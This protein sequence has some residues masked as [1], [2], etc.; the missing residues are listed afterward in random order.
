MLLKALQRFVASEKWMRRLSPVMGPLN[1]FLPE[2]RADPYATWN[3]LREE[4]PI[5]YSR[6]FGAWFV[7]RYEDCLE[8]LSS[9]KASAD[10]RDLALMKWVLWTNRNEPEFSGFLQRSLLMLEGADHRRL[11]GLVSKAFTPR[12]VAALR[13]RLEAL[14]DETLERLAS[15]GEVELVHEF[16]YP[17]PVTAIA[18]LLGVP[19]ED[20]ERFHAWTSDL[21]QI[22]DPFQG[23]GGAEPMRRATRELYAYFRSL[24]E[25]RRREPRDD[26]MTAMLH[27][28]EDGQKLD[29]ND[30]LALCVLLLAAGHE[31]TANLIGNSVVTLLRHPGERKRLHDDPTLLPTAVNELLR[32]ESPIQLTDRAIVEDFELGGRVFKKGQLVGIGIAAANRDP[33]QFEDPD[34]LDLGRDPNA[35]VA[36]GH[37]SHFCLGSQLAKLETEVAL[38]ALLRRYPDFRGSSDPPSWRRSMLLRGPATLP[39]KL[40]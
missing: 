1:P 8:L 38:G 21:V 17:F 15:R 32:F 26:L 14:A 22:L 40:S 36:L 35:H 20:H 6:I 5:F 25:A 9:S 27:A 2:H 30:L 13:P 29:E 16:A 12:R 37:G 4:T 23:Q 10:R 39:I 19:V 7:T 24:L 11:R 3:R 33:R 18:E 31:T 34:R 28:E